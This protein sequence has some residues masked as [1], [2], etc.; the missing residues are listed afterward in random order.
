MFL[1]NNNRDALQASLRS[2]I[3]ALLKQAPNPEKLSTKRLNNLIFSCRGLRLREFMELMGER[4]FAAAVHSLTGVRLGMA[5]QEQRQQ[6][7]EAMASDPGKGK[8]GK[9]QQRQNRD[10]PKGQKAGGNLSKGKIEG[11]GKKREL[12]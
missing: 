9:N 11:K 2:W 12:N 1:L 7:K 10:Y 5:A 3:F 4:D 6:E 8:E